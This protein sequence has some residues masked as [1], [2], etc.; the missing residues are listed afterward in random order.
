MA[1]GLQ[2]IGLQFWW[3]YERHVN[4]IAYIVLYEAQYQEPIGRY[5]QTS[6]FVDVPASG[7]SRELYASFLLITGVE[8]DVTPY[9]GCKRE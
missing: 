6:F 3:A 8:C 4:V 1:S 5:D 7:Q 2:L 9:H